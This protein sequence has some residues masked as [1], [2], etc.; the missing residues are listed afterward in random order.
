MNQD[1]AF[2]EIVSS[3]TR[4]REII[5]APDTL[6]LDKVIDRMDIHVRTFIAHCPYV[7]ISTADADGRCD[8]SPRG[9]EPGFI[10]IIDERRFLIPESIGNR[11]AD[12]ISNILDNPFVGMLFLIPGYEETLRVNGRATITEDRGLLSEC[13]VNGRTPDIGIGVTIDDC[14]LHCAKASIRSSLW[15]PMGWPDLAEFPP[16]AEILCDHTGA[17]HGNGSI[18]HMRHV[19]HES[20]TQRL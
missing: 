5:K 19:L 16:A 7:V 6:V 1:H 18:D 17:R 15:N 20:Y 13:S 8:A 12:S 9:G 14:Y 10:K 3:K 11:R 4:L 2:G